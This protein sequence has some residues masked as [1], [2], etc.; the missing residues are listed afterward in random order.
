MRKTKDTTDFSVLCPASLKGYKKQQK[1]LLGYF[2]YRYSGYS[3]QRAENNDWYYMSNTDMLKAT[4][5][6][7]KTTL[8]VYIRQFI[9]D[10]VIEMQTGDRT[11]ANLYRL[12][13]PY[14]DS[15]FNY[16]P[17]VEGV[18][19]KCTTEHI[20]IE[21]TD[22]KSVPPF[23]G[24]NVLPKCT[25]LENTQSVL[26]NRLKLRKLAEKVYYLLRIGQSVL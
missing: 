19:P 4:G 24:E 6:A 20:D 18:L 23:E 3:R 17:P 11:H 1:N 7:S 14:R 26:P 13:E 15:R 16:V 8:Y 12:T 9:A 10:G 5:I 21:E 2:M 25:T 22:K